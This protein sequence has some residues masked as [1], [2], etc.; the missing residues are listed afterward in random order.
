MK[1]YIGAD[2]RGFELKQQLVPWLQ[3]EGHDVVDCGNSVLDPLDDFPDFSFAVA[4]A[5]SADPEHSRGIIIC[6]SGG[7]VTIAANKVK[8]IRC[9]TASN[10]SEVKHNRTNNDVNM[11]A[12]AAD[13]TSFDKAKKF[14]KIFLE[15]KFS[16]EEKYKRRIAKITEYESCCGCC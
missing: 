3:K 14:M 9:D 16:G 11:I 1:V 13:Y 6:G 15:T 8:S 7:G 10:L 2:H 12:L 5:V 4:D